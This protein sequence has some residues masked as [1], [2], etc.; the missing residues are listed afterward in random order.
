[1]PHSLSLRE[2]GVGH[3]A[4][5]GDW[6]V[7]PPPSLAILG[8]PVPTTYVVDSRVTN[9]LVKRRT[10]NPSIC[11]QGTLVALGERL[12]HCY[13]G[14]RPPGT[15]GRHGRKKTRVRAHDYRR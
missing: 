9:V 15:D 14:G 2:T 5:S 4:V 1:M 8:E 13:R 3:T 7:I 12:L 10:S 6:A 11:F